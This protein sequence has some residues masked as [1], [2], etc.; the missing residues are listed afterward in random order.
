MRDHTPRRRRHPYPDHVTNDDIGAHIGRTGGWLRLLRSGRVPCPVPLPAPD[1]TVREQNRE[2]LLWRRERLS[3]FEA[4]FRAH[5]QALADAEI[6]GFEAHLRRRR[7]ES[8]AS[9][10]R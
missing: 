3:E 6:A 8:E 10:E 7:A 2:I 1:R 9:D 5:V 4:W